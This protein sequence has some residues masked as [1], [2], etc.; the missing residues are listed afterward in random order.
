M[1]NNLNSFMQR[2]SFQWTYVN[3][4]ALR[5]VFTFRRRD[6]TL[7]KMIPFI[8]LPSAFLLG[9]SHLV[10]HTANYIFLISCPLHLFNL[11]RSQTGIEEQCSFLLFPLIFLL[12][13]TSPESKSLH[14]SKSLLDTSFLNRP[15]SSH[16]P[17]CYYVMPFFVVLVDNLCTM[18]S[19]PDFLYALLGSFLH[20]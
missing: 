15:H 3:P 12:P 11:R 10:I 8:G 1:P 4:S 2:F 17:C 5:G 19:D 14:Y 16:L 20:F 7:L 6:L 13:K 9:K 18:L